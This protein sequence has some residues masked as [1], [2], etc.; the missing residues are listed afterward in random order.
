MSEFSTGAQAASFEWSP[1][2][3][4]MVLFAL[5]HGLALLFAADVRGPFLY[6]LLSNTEVTQSVDV[7]VLLL[8][9]GMAPAAFIDLEIDR[10]SKLFSLVIYFAIYI[11]CVVVGPAVSDRPLPEF[12]LFLS[13][14]FLSML[15]VAV[16]ISPSPRAL[17]ILSIS[18]SVYVACLAILNVAMLAFCLARIDVDL[19]WRPFNEIYDVRETLVDTWALS[20]DA[21]LAY[22][23]QWLTAATI[24]ALLAMGLIWRVH[25]ATLLAA[26]L[27]YVCYQ[28]FAEKSALA[29]VLAVGWVVLAMVF[30]R[31]AQLDGLILIGFVMAALTAVLCL[32][33]FFSDP[34]FLATWYMRTFL[35]P[36]LLTSFYF[37]FFTLNPLA[38][39]GDSALG[40]LFGT[41]SASENIPL[42]IGSIYVYPGA[43]ANAN[44]W[45]DGYGN[46]GILG[47]VV[48]SVVLRLFIFAIDVVAVGRDVRVVFAA[49]VPIIFALGNTALQR[50]VASNGLWL[51][52]LFIMFLP[53]DDP[54]RPLAELDESLDSRH[55]AEGQEDQA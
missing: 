50:V 41:Q 49:S 3:L 54:R 45:A 51:L 4:L 44:L 25:W 53:T 26:V 10:P 12:I 52:I 31:R 9:I 8:L 17:V 30:S 21:L 13:A 6:D 28:A 19:T 22:T 20:T 1:R 32:D 7:V 24:P 55:P 35:T 15:I 36:G 23:K 43:W 42:V 39:F 27:A 37:D 38:W 34:F 2:R 5:L 11:P 33:Y 40:A 47:I 18:P 16:P 14:I 48:V 29:N 46:L